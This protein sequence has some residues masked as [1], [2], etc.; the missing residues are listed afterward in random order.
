MTERFKQSGYHYPVQEDFDDTT[1][2][3]V[4]LIVFDNN[5]ILDDTRAKVNYLR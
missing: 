1:L 5:N 4:I 2:K 3:I